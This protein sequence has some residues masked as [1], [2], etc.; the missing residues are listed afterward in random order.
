[1]ME[2]RFARD[3]G[4]L[5]AIFEFIREFLAAHG[6]D[7]RHAWDLDLVVEELFTNLVKYGRGREAISIE[8]DRRDLDAIVRLR[9]FDVDAFDPRLAPEVD[10]GRPLEERRSGGLG[11]HFVRQIA[12]HID[13][14]YRERRSTITVTKRLIA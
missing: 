3:V 7:E 14:E 1:M 9:D 6:I 4:S 5:A 12:D 13:Y 11:I 10:Q 8:L 2:R